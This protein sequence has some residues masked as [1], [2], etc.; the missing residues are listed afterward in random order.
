VDSGAWPFLIGRTRDHG[1]RIIVIPDFMTDPVDAAALR[2]ATG[3]ASPDSGK[4]VLRELRGLAITPVSVVYRSFLLRGSDYGLGSDAILTDEFG[5]PIPLVEGLAFRQSEAA[6]RAH[7]VTSADLARA[8]AAVTNAYQAF[9]SDGTTF[10]RRASAALRVGECDQR[11]AVD[12]DRTE[13]WVARRQALVHEAPNSTSGRS[14]SEPNL[15]GA[16]AAK[17]ALSGAPAVEPPPSRRGHVSAA[18]FLVLAL[19]LALA[20]L[21]ILLIVNLASPGPPPHKPQPHQTSQTTGQ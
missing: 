3:I 11:P 16:P 17:L 2:D 10:A 13:P 19:A 20:A 4:V 21:L 1:H 18:R 14:A 7:G 9:W 5:R 15:S 8:H 6:V 12:L